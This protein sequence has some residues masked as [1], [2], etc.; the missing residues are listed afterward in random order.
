MGTDLP[1]EEFAYTDSPNRSIGQ[2]PFQIMY[3]MQPRGVS[4]LRDL[5]KSEFISVGAEDF[6]AEM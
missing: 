1:Q 5:E 3:G 4:D 2:S 6:A